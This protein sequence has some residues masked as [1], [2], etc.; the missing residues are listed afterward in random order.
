MTQ[1]P[2]WQ[3]EAFSVSYISAWAAHAGVTVAHSVTPADMEAVDLS[4]RNSGLIVDLQLKCTSSPQLSANGDFISFPLDNRAFRLLTGT[5]TAEAY[6]ALVIAPEEALAWIEPSDTSILMRGS[7]YYVRMTG[8]GE[9]TGV[10]HT[11]IRVPCSQRIDLDGIKVMF[12]QAEHRLLHGVL[13]G[14]A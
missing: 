5:R 3:K 8:L 12:D 10:E 9:P 13:G 7:G 2:T 1:A 4:L 6:L 11:V 14:S